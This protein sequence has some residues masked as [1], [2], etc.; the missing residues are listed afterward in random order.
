MTN[1]KYQVQTYIDCATKE[2]IDQL[3]AKYQESVSSIMRRALIKFLEMEEKNN[4][5]LLSSW[6]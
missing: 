5:W 4:A 1:K 6:Y 3:C 2:K